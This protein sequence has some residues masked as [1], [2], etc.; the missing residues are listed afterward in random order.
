METKKLHRQLQRLTKQKEQ[1]ESK[2]VGNEQNFTYHGGF[3]LGYIKGQ[4]S[5]LENLLDEVGVDIDAVDVVT[6]AEVSL[7]PLEIKA[8]P[9]T[10]V[11]Q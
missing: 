10:S 8:K 5:I 3:S 6:H 2:H 9:E 11:S 4:I 7:E 1:L